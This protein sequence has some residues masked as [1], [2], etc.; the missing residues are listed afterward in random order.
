MQDNS[1]DRIIISDSSCLIGLT[2]IG[3]LEI[4]NQLYK[5][6]I[7]T[8]EVASEYKLPLPKWIIIKDS[9]NK[10]IIT[11]TKKLKF[12]KGES[13]SIAL[14][15]EVKNSLLVLD[16]DR[17]RNFARNKGLSIIG[18]ITI[19]GNA[20]DKGYIDS[21]EDACED[22]RKVHFRF[23]QKIQDEVRNNILNNKQQNTSKHL[24]RGM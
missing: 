23:T 11:E 21:Y 12:G 6:I 15:M 9:K 3:K 10:D 22:L 2:N 4:L 19:I 8:P 5:E 17:A 20:Y 7:I 24:K 1:F 13:S 16:D 18:T 14:A